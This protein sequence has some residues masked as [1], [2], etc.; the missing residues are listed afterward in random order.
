MPNPDEIVRGTVGGES[1]K[2]TLTDVAKRFSVSPKGAGF[3]ITRTGDSKFTVRH[4]LG[5]GGGG[6]APRILYVG[7]LHGIGQVLREHLDADVVEDIMDRVTH[8]PIQG[9]CMSGRGSPS[10]A[11]SATI[12]M[13]RE[14]QPE[15][16][17]NA[18]PG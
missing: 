15:H 10:F 12:G 13:P 6:G 8:V 7:N 2:P 14:S 4:L 18:L 11:C 9:K 16:T 3:S 17:R 5:P 1:P